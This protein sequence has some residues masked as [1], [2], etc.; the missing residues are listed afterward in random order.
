MISIVMVISQERML[1]SFYHI[2]QSVILLPRHQF[3]KVDSPEKVEEIR[4]SSIVF[5]LKKKFHCLLSMSLVKSQESISKITFIS[6][7]KYLQKCF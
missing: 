3:K 6:I 7:K 2:F 1:D 5:R 4:F